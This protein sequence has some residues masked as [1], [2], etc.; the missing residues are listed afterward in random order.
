MEIAIQGKQ[1]SSE[2]KSNYMITLDANGGKI[3]SSKTV[4][5]QVTIGDTYGDLPIPEKEGYTFLGWSENLAEVISSDNYSFTNFNN[6]TSSEIKVGANINGLINQN[7]CK[8]TGNQSNST[9]DTMWMIT[10]KN[11]INVKENETYT[12]SFYIKSENAKATQYMEVWRTGGISGKTSLQ[13][14]NGMTTYLQNIKNFENDGKW[15]LITEK[16]IVPE[17]VTSG[18]ISIGNDGPNLYG[19]GSYVDVAGIQFTKGETVAPYYITN[20][21]NVTQNSNHKLYAKWIKD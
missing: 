4:T 18:K 10:S 21:T 12:L 16:I 20:E 7:Y 15:H 5:K 17:G 9:I 2:P 11:D 19:E 8:I 13:W 1:E 6:R 3:G 14:N